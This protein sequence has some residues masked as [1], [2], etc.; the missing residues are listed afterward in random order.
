MGRGGVPQTPAIQEPPRLRRQPQSDD[1]TKKE[2]PPLIPLPSPLDRLDIKPIIPGPIDAPS[3]EDINKG[4]GALKGSGQGGAG[5]VD[6]APGWRK[7][8]DGMCCEGSS[9]DRC[10]PPYRLTILGRCCPT[11][12]YAKGA[13]CVKFD[14]LTPT[15]PGL[16]GTGTKDGGNPSRS[17]LPPPERNLAPTPPLTVSMDIYFKLDRPGSVVSDQKALRDSLTAAG[18][19]TLDGVVTWLKNGPQFKVQL[20]G[21]ASIEGPAAHNRELGEYRVRSVAHALA[22]AGIS[23]D[24]LADPLLIPAACAKLEDGIHNCGDTTASK[25]IDERD[26][27]VR[28]TLFIPRGN[29]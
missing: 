8:V 2:P 20:T 27:Q 23:A 1:Q 11:D 9:V 4:L 18:S 13:D 5:N 7:R 26:R 25:T 10:C 17:D 24:R 21:K 29:P 3:L 14:L 12:R 19:V 15:L 6:C 16:P 28:A 22:E